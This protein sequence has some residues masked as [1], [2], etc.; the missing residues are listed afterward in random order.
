MPTAC[1]GRDSVLIVGASKTGTTGL[2]ASVRAAYRNAGHAVRAFFEP[3]RAEQVDNA[4]RFAPDV[5]V[6]VKV[7]LQRLERTGFESAAFERRLTT[8]RDPRD[9]AISALLFRPVTAKAVRRIDQATLEVFLA[10][11]QRKEADPS[12]IS[13]R[14][15]FELQASLGI[16]GPPSGVLKGVLDRHVAL[17][18]RCDFH[19]VKYEQFVRNELTEV[20]AYL[21]L[22]I[23]NVPTATSS[24]FGHIA[25][26][27][28]SGDF[29]Q[30]FRDD[31]L[32]YFND[33]FRDEIT[34]FGYTLDVALEPVRALDPATGSEYVRS[35]YRQRRDVLQA[36]RSQDWP[37][38]D[39]VSP[40]AL[41]A[42]TEAA[43]HGD[44][45]AAERV[46][47][48]TLSGQLRGQD[49]ATALR[50]ATAAAELGSTSAMRTAAELQR[51]LQPDGAASIRAARAW[52]IEYRHRQTLPDQRVDAVERKLTR[53]YSSGR[54][55]LGA[56]L[57]ALARS[58]FRE[59]A[60]TLRDLIALRRGALPRRQTCQ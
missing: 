29:R 31:D 30:W 3:A 10:A 54:Y 38:R 17:T 12:S 16:S 35:R 4:F 5:P 43:E 21:G 22:P 23:H 27:G 50:W 51:R 26:A 58:P 53:L 41:A 2:Y 8:V 56:A 40:E 46:T 34:T 42:L 33:L 36:L 9:I 6:V 48:L 1:P 24:L 14:E 25:R 55:R 52:E 7:T 57:V 37:P 11:L 39:A 19:V 20:S 28:G 49:Q 47:A 13:V 44:L 45:D 60:K 59:G 18:E 32:A 15:L